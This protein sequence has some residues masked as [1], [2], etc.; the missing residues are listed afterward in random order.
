MEPI[1]KAEHVSKTFGTG[2]AE[3][4]VLTDVSLEIQK[5]EF[6]SLMGESGSGKS[7]L[8]YLVGGLDTQYEGNI[9]IAGQK[10]TG[11]KEAE[12]SALR[13][14]KIGF[15]F[16]FYNLIQNL[17]VEDNILL[18]IKM[19]GKTVPGY[20]EKL[21][22]ILEITGL[23]PKRKSKPS[24]LSGGQQQRVSI[25]RAVLSEPEILL[26]DEPTGNLDSKSTAE[27]MELFKRINDE[28]KITIL[29]VTHSPDTAEY[30]NRIIRLDSGKLV[31]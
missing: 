18:P 21:E 23:T 29:Q 22:E 11:M 31:G 2:E 1:M 14:S 4:R 26:A 9:Y 28:K 20:K 16:Q 5:G 17:S 7:T 27:I 6:A 8:L 13:L 12:M 30:G 24:Q 25:A 3:T 10:M 19:A 15:V